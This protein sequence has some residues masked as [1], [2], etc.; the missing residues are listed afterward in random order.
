M[1]KKEFTLYDIF[2]ALPDVGKPTERVSVDVKTRETFD[3]VNAFFTVHGREPEDTEDADYEERSLAKKL[4]R[5]RSQNGMRENLR[6]FDTYGLLGVEVAAKTDVETAPFAT[7]EPALAAPA[8]PLDAEP[9]IASEDELGEVPSD[10]SS[11][12][13]ALDHVEEGMTDIFNMR[14][15]QSYHQTFSQAEYTSQRE[16]CP[17]FHEYK[18][19]FDQVNTG[20]KN[21]LREPL[22][23]RNEQ[24]IR[25]G[26]FFI[27]NGI[28]VF[29]AKVGEFFEKNSKKNARLKVIFSNGTQGN[30]LLRSLATELYKDPN[31]RRIS[32]PRV[33]GL[34]LG[35]AED[36]DVGT[37]VVYVLQSLSKQ[38]SVADN[39]E[40]LHKIG[41][42]RGSVQQRI[43]NAENEP[44]YLL[45]PV[46][47]VAEFEVYNIKA[48][49][50]EKLLHAYFD[51]ARAE[52][53]IPDRFGKS[54]RSREW[55]LVP[56]SAIKEAVDRLID[57]SL[58]NTIYDP[59]SARIVCKPQGSKP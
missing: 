1:T 25:Q 13:D 12:F 37:G 4:A 5:I 8:R 18:P 2:A 58:G 19:L 49:S 53:T 38:P 6:E 21:G 43:A 10:L 39:R 16:P 56:R 35:I 23:F 54:V 28:M 27:L 11:I 47:I 45:A 17:N 52:I 9:I 57:G 15:V 20:L 59:H 26:Q 14:H 34:F 44:T 32:D 7:A 29:V 24:E 31:G 3:Q 33:G 36:D 51:R 46:K 48:R 41:V 30:N 40:V 55:F 50:I 42:T 22:Q